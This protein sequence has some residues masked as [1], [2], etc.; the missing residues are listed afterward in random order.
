MPMTPEEKGAKALAR[1]FDSVSLNPATLAYLTLNETTEA[2][3]RVLFDFLMNL[4]KQYSLD[5][6]SGHVTTDRAQRYMLTNA[7]REAIEREGYYMP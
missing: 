6:L 2:Q 4:V 5:D 7:M 1:M 3:Q